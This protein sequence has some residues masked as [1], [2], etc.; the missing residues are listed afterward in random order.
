MTCFDLFPS[1]SFWSAWEELAEMKYA[2]SIH[3][4]PFILFSFFPLKIV[5]VMMHYI[6]L[7]TD[8]EIK[9]F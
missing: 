5:D 6:Y 1:S 9:W 4:V 7:D 8:V 3:S 2:S